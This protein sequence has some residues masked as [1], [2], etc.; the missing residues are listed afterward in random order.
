[1]HLFTACFL[2]LR[3]AKYVKK[4]F[5]SLSSIQFESLPLGELHSS[6]WQHLHLHPPLSV[7]TSCTVTDKAHKRLHI[8]NTGS[9]AYPGQP[10]GSHL[11][12]YVPLLRNQT[13]SLCFSRCYFFCYLA[14]SHH[15]SN[16]YSLSCIQKRQAVAPD[17]AATHGQ[18]C[19]SRMCVE[20]GRLWP[21]W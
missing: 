16:G 10:T 2:H 13:Y 5:Q 3:V 20:E 7:S 18:R 1:M 14:S 17:I 21:W 19:H 11:F 9:S 6:F 12:D 8:L 15:G 4:A